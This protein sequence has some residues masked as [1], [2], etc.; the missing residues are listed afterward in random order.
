MRPSE[1][2][3]DADHGEPELGAAPRDELAY[4]LRQQELL[5]EF[6]LFA[7]RCRD[8]TELHQHA[9]RVAADGMNVELAKF[10]EY[11]ARNDTLLI[12]AGVGWHPGTIGSQSLGADL[13]SPAG[14]AFQ[15]RQA[16]ISNHLENE[17]RFRTPPVLSEHGVRRAMNVPVKDGG[18]PFGIL[19]VDATHAGKFTQADIAF[20]QGL[21]NILSVGIERRRT[22]AELAQTRERLTIL[23][24]ELRHRV[25]NL[26]AVSASLISTARRETERLGQPEKALDLA[27][28]RIQALGRANEV[29]I[30]HA[31]E[32]NIETVS[33]VDPIELTKEVLSPYGA[34]VVVS[35][36]TSELNASHTTALALLLHELATNAVKYGALRE[37]ADE[38][39][40]VVEWSSDID[41]SG[42]AGFSWTETGGPVLS[43]PP[44]VTDDGFGT[45]M[46]DALLR[47]IGGTITREWRVE[48]LHVRVS[49]A[50]EQAH[51]G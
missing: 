50:S 3:G 38:G 44:A 8:E 30:G 13:G 23:A 19:E 35:G 11:D 47:S 14:Y 46:A 6:G 51:I 28:G 15:T 4:R 39:R 34:R 16:V 32:R 37:D 41:E 45:R 36:E 7:L 33:M 10:L 24:G 42:A 20:M 29:G 48:G 25:K 12:T 21:A 17:T 31:D 43:E 49:L 22:E 2:V 1:T 27:L 26:F 5:S 18:D 9:T 40:I